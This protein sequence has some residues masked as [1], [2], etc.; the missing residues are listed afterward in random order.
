[1]GS[2]QTQLQ[3]VCIYLSIRFL[4]PLAPP[5][6]APAAAPIAAPSLAFIPGARAPMTA[7]PTAPLTAPPANPLATGA[8]FSRRSF[9]SSRVMVIDL[10]KYWCLS[11]PFTFVC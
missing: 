4:T 8:R 6:A 2:H 9:L 10:Y 3:Y 1:M 5:T 11:F 7:P